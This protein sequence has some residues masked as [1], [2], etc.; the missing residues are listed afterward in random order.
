MDGGLRKVEIVKVEREEVAA[1]PEGQVFHFKPEYEQDCYLLK[2]GEY[3]Y[4]FSTIFKDFLPRVYQ[5]ALYFIVAGE[6]WV[7]TFD[8]HEDY[9]KLVTLSFHLPGLF[10]DLIIVDFERDSFISVSQFDAMYYT[11]GKEHDSLFYYTGGGFLE[12]A[13]IVIVDQ[14]RVLK[15]WDDCDG[16]FYVDLPEAPPAENPNLA[17]A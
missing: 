8:R 10:I 5:T 16:T 1:L 3:V 9:G 12:G 17:S 14:R 2:I 6:S 7:A 13:E 4:G 15:L 11:K